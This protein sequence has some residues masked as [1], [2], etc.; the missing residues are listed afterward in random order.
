MKL[1]LLQIKLLKIVK[2]TSGGR[3]TFEVW[4]VRY[5]RPPSSIYSSR[6]VILGVDKL[7]NRLALSLPAAMQPPE[8][9]EAKRAWG[10]WI[11]WM[12]LPPHRITHV[13]S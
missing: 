6:M 4:C 13:G 1:A 10:G 12:G 9:R 2:A 5:E 3:E 8:K 11:D 7:G